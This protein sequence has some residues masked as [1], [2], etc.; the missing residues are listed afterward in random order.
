MHV[1]PGI[2]KIGDRVS[3][4]LNRTAKRIVS[5][6]TDRNSGA[7]GY[8]LYLTEDI[9]REVSRRAAHVPA[10]Q[11]E[12]VH[13]RTVLVSLLV[14]EKLFDCGDSF[15]SGLIDLY[16]RPC[17]SVCK[18]AVVPNPGITYLYQ[19]ILGIPLVRIGAVSC[20]ISISLDGGG[21]AAGPLCRNL[22][23]SSSNLFERS[24]FFTPTIAVTV[25][26]KCH[27]GPKSCIKD[28]MNQ[29]P[30]NHTL[31]IIINQ[32]ETFNPNFRLLKNLFGISSPRRPRH[33]INARTVAQST[34]IP[35]MYRT[36]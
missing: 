20:H 28:Q 34:G 7:V 17:G 9:K 1:I 36:E 21:D 23:V 32:T 31:A 14:R 19:P 26:L 11:E 33:F 18:F 25:S 6:F 22:M 27:Y 29:L 24:W 5:E 10:E 15:T 2:L 35:N 30:T 16:T 13:N 12:L 3:Q 4:K 8:L